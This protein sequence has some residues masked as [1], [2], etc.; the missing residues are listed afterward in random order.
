MIVQGRFRRDQNHNLV[1]DLRI[2]NQTGGNIAD[3]DIM[4]N[5]NPFGI[6][7]QGAANKIAFPANGGTTEGTLECTVDKKNLDAKNPPKSPFMV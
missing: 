2:T 6:F 7:I 4:F 3:F 1:L 5:K